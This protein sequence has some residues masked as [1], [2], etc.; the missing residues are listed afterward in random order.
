MNLR[1][2]ARRSEIGIDITPVVDVV[3]I[4]LI[5]LLISTTFRTREH[6]FTIVLPRATETRSVVTA[7]RPTVYVTREGEIFLYVPSSEQ[8][9][10]VE[11][12]PIRSLDELEVR[13]ERLREGNPQVGV[14]VKADSTTEYQRI[15]DVVNQCYRSGIERVF[16]PFRPAAPE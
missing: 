3:F 8:G 15:M 4:L 14:S 6:A 1:R 7:K 9:D 16:F 2:A 5:F 12:V 10:A 11:G 13:L